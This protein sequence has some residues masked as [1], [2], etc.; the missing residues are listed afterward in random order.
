M[1]K[2]HKTVTEKELRKNRKHQRNLSMRDDTESREKLEFLKKKELE[3]L[4]K[5]KHDKERK[6]KRLQKNEEKERLENMT[7]E[8]TCKYFKGE[9]NTE[10]METSDNIFPNNRVSRIHRRRVIQ[11]IQEYRENQC[12]Q[13]RLEMRLKLKAFIEG[14]ESKD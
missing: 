10:D 6:E 14:I 12:F 4:K 9:K 5:A 3:I 13:E 2:K 8:Q 1:V 7:F 11:G